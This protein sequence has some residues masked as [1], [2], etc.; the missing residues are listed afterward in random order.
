M[1]SP[2]ITGTERDAATGRW[3]PGGA[4]PSH[5]PKGSVGGR[6]QALLMLDSVMA[7]EQNK[8]KLRAAI[9]AE[10]DRNPMRF[11]RTVIMP[12]LPK[13]MT[14]RAAREEGP[15]QWVSLLTKLAPPGGAP[16]T[17]QGDEQGRLASPSLGSAPA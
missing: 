8:T 11:F 7:E 6:A 17:V 2:V 10:F 15:I 16:P 3:L 5:R 12:L 9:Q 14:L 13:D 1:D 4:P